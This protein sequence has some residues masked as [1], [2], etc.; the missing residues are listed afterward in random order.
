MSKGAYNPD[1][2]R[3]L[4]QHAEI[5]EQVQVHITR[6]PTLGKRQAPIQDSL[7][8]FTWDKDASSIRREITSVALGNWVQCIPDFLSRTA[9]VPVALLQTLPDC[10]AA[11]ARTLTGVCCDAFGDY[12]RRFKIRRERREEN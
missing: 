11:R 8:H 10:P 9:V 5:L 4:F 7:L 3:R 6:T 2:Y 1:Y 12:R